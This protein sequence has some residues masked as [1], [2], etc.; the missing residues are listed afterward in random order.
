MGMFKRDFLKLLLAVPMVFMNTSHARNKDRL[1][2]SSLKLFVPAWLIDKNNSKR[3]KTQALSIKEAAKSIVILFD[4]DKPLP[5]NPDTSVKS[6]MQKSNNRPT[7]QSMLL[8]RILAYGIDAIYYSLRE[9]RHPQ[10]GTPSK[11][12]FDALQ[13]EEVIDVVTIGAVYNLLTDLADRKVV[14][15]ITWHSNK[16]AFIIR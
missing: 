13:A 1:D 2:I 5:L 6:L 16:Q 15:A 10:L 14:T 7:R 3:A 4:G 8:K 9:K 12:S 11:S